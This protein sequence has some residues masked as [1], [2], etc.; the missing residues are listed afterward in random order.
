MVMLVK[1]RNI[2]MSNLTN[3]LEQSLKIVSYYVKIITYTN[4]F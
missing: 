4:I 3:K 1:D 2:P